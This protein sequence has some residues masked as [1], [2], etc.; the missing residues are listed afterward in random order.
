MKAGNLGKQKK[1]FFKQNSNVVPTIGGKNP[2]SKEVIRR[3]VNPNQTPA[4]KPTLRKRLALAVKMG[5]GAL[6]VSTA[7]N[8]VNKSVT[9]AGLDRLS[10]QNELRAKTTMVEKTNTPKYTNRYPKVSPEIASKEM[11][12]VAKLLKLNLSKEADVKISD[13]VFEVARKSGVSPRVALRTLARSSGR[14]SAYN[15]KISLQRQRVKELEEIGQFETANKASYILQQIEKMQK[16]AE[17]R[18]KLPSES[19]E[20]LLSRLSAL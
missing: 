15:E 19:R 2:L 9:R 1:N 17:E 7:L 3:A 14:A 16:I 6:V 18:D 10:M 4:T 11:K 20:L 13:A 8:L 12:E 5:L